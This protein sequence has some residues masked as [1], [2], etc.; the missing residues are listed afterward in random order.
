M[1]IE[2]VANELIAMKTQL[3]LQESAY[4]LKRDEMYNRLGSQ[5]SETYAHGGYR[6]QR[7]D[8]VTF[9]SVNKQNFIGSL[10]NAGLSE[11]I[12]QQII[13]DALSES[14]RESGIRITKINA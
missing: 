10:F 3:D 6:F 2:E 9:L 13:S 11:Q 14:V 1:S 8:Q 12:R 4:N 7:T 5:P